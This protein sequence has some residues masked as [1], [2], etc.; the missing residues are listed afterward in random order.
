[1][2]QR[3]LRKALRR[4]HVHSVR[5]PSFV[6][7]KGSGFR[8]NEKEK[9]MKNTNGSQKREWWNSKTGFILACVG[10]AVGMGNI[11]LFPYR[12]ATYGGSFLLVYLIF[13]VLLGFSGVVGEMSFGRAVR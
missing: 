1:M 10:S 2:R 6:Q 13:D 9:M 11:W 7:K 12:M 4:R 5:R 3:D 8:E